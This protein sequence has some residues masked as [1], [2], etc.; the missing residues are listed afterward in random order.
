[1]VLLLGWLDGVC[2]YS[3][4]D[5]PGRIWDSAEEQDL[6]MDFEAESVSVILYLG[7]YCMPLSFWFWSANGGTGIN[8]CIEA[9]EATGR[10]GKAKQNKAT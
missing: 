10:Q 7:T 6:E 4:F 3:G 5:L 9:S 2:S 8:N 1:M